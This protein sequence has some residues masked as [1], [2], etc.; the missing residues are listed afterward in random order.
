MFVK[1]FMDILLVTVLLFGA[2]FGYKKGFLK[3]VSRPIRFFA[4]VFTAI[5]ISDPISRKIIE[6]IVKTPV[7]N[8]IKGYLLENC[9]G[10]TPESALEELP[11]LLKFSASFLDVDVSSLSPEN[12]IDA[13]VDSLASP[14]V[15]IVSLIF[16]FIFVYFISKLLYSLLISLVSSR[17]NSGAIGL[18]NKLLGAF[19]GLIFAVALAW[20]VTLIFDFVI[21]LSVFEDVAWAVNFEGGALYGFFSKNSP[22]DIL[23]G[24]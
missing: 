11:T 23:L 8:Q 3:S 2:V 20:I 16:T 9:P 5:S 15:H 7:T 19:F 12:T 21:H 6:P 13:I 17:F 22:I 1:I 10:I 24:F 14:V 18:P 4:A